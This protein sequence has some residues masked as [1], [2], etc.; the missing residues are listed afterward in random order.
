MSQKLLESK[1]ANAAYHARPELSSTQI[2]KYLD[3]AVKWYRTYV[4][5]EISKDAPTPAMTFG[6]EVHEMLE[7]GRYSPKEYVQIPVDVLGK[8]NRKAG[9][10]WADFESSHPPGTLFAKPGEATPVDELKEV[11]ANV[12]A[13]TDCCYWL[14]EGEKEREFYWTDEATG[15]KCRCKLDVWLAA[16]LEIVDWKT[17]KAG[18]RYAF[19]RECYQ[20]NYFERLA[21]YRRGVAANLG[22]DR[23][24][25]SISVGAIENNGSYR[26]TPYRINPHLVEA[27]EARL[28]EALAAMANFNIDDERD[29]KTTYLEN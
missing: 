23:E 13:N 8:G 18:S 16:D 22:I 24:Q 9:K 7:T 29:Q 15:I 11:W 28:T 2:G 3:D 26:V 12:T 20:R 6:T 17:T 25:L 10:K 14:N 27:G 21:F 19:K 5:K 4:S 1:A